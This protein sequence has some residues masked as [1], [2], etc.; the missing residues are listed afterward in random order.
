[1]FVL[2]LEMSGK[3]LAVFF[4][5]LLHRSNPFALAVRVIAGTRTLYNTKSLRD[6]LVWSEMIFLHIGFTVG[7]LKGVGPLSRDDGRRKCGS[8]K[9]AAGKVFPWKKNDG[10]ANKTMA[11]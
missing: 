4:L 2:V 5:D 8:N 1:M 3:D 9:L 7:A 6:Q 10:Q 11:I